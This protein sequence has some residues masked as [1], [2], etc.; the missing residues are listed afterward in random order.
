VL[1]VQH[2]KK[3]W[4]Y[5][6]RSMSEELN[7][8][9]DMVR[10]SSA[11]VHWQRPSTPT[12]FL[13]L[14]HCQ[15]VSSFGSQLSLSWVLTFHDSYYCIVCLMG[16]FPILVHDIERFFECLTLESEAHEMCVATRH[17]NWMKRGPER[18]I[19]KEARNLTLDGKRCNSFRGDDL[20][21]WPST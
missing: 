10:R 19:C 7:V 17:G 2:L 1:E 6:A 16:Q 4:A 8:H 15:E 11:E 3:M 13:F 21:R 5:G 9:F 20:C 14:W 12:L 18:W